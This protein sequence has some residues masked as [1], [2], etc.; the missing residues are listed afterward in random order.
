M[1]LYSLTATTEFGLRPV[2]VTIGP[3]SYVN[4][5]NPNDMI[6]GGTE[7]ISLSS[8]SSSP[9]PPPVATDDPEDVVIPDSVMSTIDGLISS[10]FLSDAVFQPDYLQ[11]LDQLNDDED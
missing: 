4:T 3:A 8:S 10:G 2:R 11:S 5:T 9:S 6:K 1:Q 7:T